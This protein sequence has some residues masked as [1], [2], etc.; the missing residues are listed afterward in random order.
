MPRIPLV[1][2]LLAL[3]VP[4][5]SAAQPAEA[6]PAADIDRWQV[7]I[8]GNPAGEMT[9]RVE[10]GE[11][12]APAAEPWTFT[13]ND[14]G[15]G[16]ELS[17]RLVLGADGLPVS[18]ETTGHDYYT[19][20]VDERFS[21]TLREDGARATW[22]GTNESGRKELSAPAFYLSYETAAAELALL[23]RALRGEPD[24][25]I[26]LLPEG[27][28]VLEGPE[29]VEVAA[30]ERR[31]RL[32]RVAITG[33]GFTPASVW[34]DED[35]S[36]FGNAGRW[37]SIVPAG[38]EGVL[39]TLVEAEERA[40]EAWAEG[41]AGRLAH[42]PEGPVALVGAGVFDP[43]TGETLPG[44]TVLIEG[45][46]IAAVGPDGEVAVPEGATRIDAA[47]KTVLPGLWDM[48]TH[49]GEVDGLLQLAAGVTSVRDMAN[50]VE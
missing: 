25:R 6:A 33:L 1:L 39:D 4:A 10:P 50:D 19:V 15:R 41:L 2:L 5:A 22:Q 29:T 13:F 9:R 34:L 48:H 42:R 43:R 31:R 24:G 27:E 30:G 40:G 16:P 14:R 45:E 12:G 26:A 11:A 18:I 3:A 32:T 20:P 8:Q 47:G 38:W 35:G 37:F 49:L 44:R 46:R 23:A 21:R 7:L 17:T 36:Y 28:A